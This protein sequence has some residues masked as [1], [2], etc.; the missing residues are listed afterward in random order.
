MNYTNKI[1]AIIVIFNP[2]INQ[3]MKTIHSLKDQV[4][5]IVII[6]NSIENLNE[7]LFLKNSKR[8]KYIPLNKNF[9]IAKAQNLGLKFLLNKKYKFILL[10]DQDTIFPDNYSEHMLKSFYSMD[11]EFIAA[12]GPNFMETNRNSKQGFEIFNGI[13]RNRIYPTF[14]IHSVSQIIASGKII[15]TKNLEKIGMMNEKLFIDWVDL[16]WCWRAKKNGFTIL[17]NA[18]VT[19]EHNLGDY[20]KDFIYKKF[21]LH[22]ATRHYYI[23]RNAIYLAL[24]S[25][26]LKIG[27]RINI[28]QKAIFQIFLFPLIGVPHLDHFKKVFLGLFHGLIG[29]LGSI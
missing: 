5:E 10:S 14:G 23:I 24:Y 2:N 8:I 7:T 15:Y 9:G 4:N 6:D 25:P 22:N 1:A 29:R 26:Y 21:T 11:S 27:M 13:F 18:N 12:I 3:L 17:G 19:I 28:L 16:E 20:S